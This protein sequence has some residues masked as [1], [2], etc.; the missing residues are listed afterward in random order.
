MHEPGSAPTSSRIEITESRADGGHRRGR[1]TLQALKALG[2][3]LILDDFGTGY[4]SLSYLHRF[5][6]DR[7]KIDRSFVAGLDGGGSSAIVSAIVSM[8]Q[9]LDIA[10][11]AEG[12]E[13]ADQLDQLRALGVNYAQGYFFGRP[14]RRPRTP[15]CSARRCGGRPAS[16]RL[17]TEHADRAGLRRRD[18]ERGGRR[19]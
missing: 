6:L 18:V 19:G 12:V 14:G 11:T 16:S 7:L 15:T 3:R 5:P 2:V 10:I 13:T 17:T 9:S 1:R 4:S 8:A